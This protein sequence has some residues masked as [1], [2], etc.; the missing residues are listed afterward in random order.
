V[1]VRAH[2]RVCSAIYVY[3]SINGSSLYLVDTFMGRCIDYLFLYLHAT[4]AS[5]CP[6]MR[7]LC[8]HTQIQG[9]PTRLCRLSIGRPEK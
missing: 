1:C 6:G 9:D 7:S 5:V 3:A 4:H 2:V 8:V